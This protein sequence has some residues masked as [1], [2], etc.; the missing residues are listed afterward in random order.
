M[1]LY[2][3]K[4]IIKVQNTKH[5]DRS[6]SDS[7]GLKRYLRSSWK[8]S[9]HLLLS[10]LQFS[11]R[12]VKEKWRKWRQELDN[13]LLVKEKDERADQ[14]KISILLNFLGSERLEIYNTFKFE[15]PESKANYSE[16]LQKFQVRIARIQSELFRSSSKV[17]NLKDSFWHVPLDEVNSEICTINTPFGRYKFNKL[18]FGIVS[19]P[20][21][22][23]KRNQKLFGDI[24]GVEIYFDDIIIAGYNKDSHDAIMSKILERARSLN[25]KFN[26]DKLQY[27][28]SEVKYV[29]QIISKSGIKLDSDHVKAI[30]AMPTPK[31]KTEVRRLLGMKNFLSKFIPNVSKVIA[32]LREIIHENVEFNWGKE[33]ELSFVNIKELLAKAPILKVFSASDEI[34][35][36][37]DSSKDRLGSCLIQKGQP[38]SFVSRSLTNSEKN[39][40]QIEKELLA[41]VFSFEKYHNF[42]YGRKVAIQSDHKPLM[43]I[44]KKPMH[45]ISSRMQRM[46]LKLLKYDFEINYVPGNQMFL[47]DTLSRAF[48]VNETMRDDPEMLNIVHTVSKHLPMSDKRLAQ[49]KKKLS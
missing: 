11:L 9:G 21:V 28:V 14:I 5:D 2:V 19:A 37:C 27:R 31:S 23:Q 25:I 34:V 18:A 48:P 42:V 3:L 45:K 36:Q 8:H 40:A 4:N 33:Q 46:I 38:V 32:P 49:L 6:L 16:V 26:P 15:S 41:I 39:Y 44:V 24:E 1:I 20:E 43:A 29:G 10:H 35:I 30:V 12:N 22:F 47:A 17:S 7:V 13:Y